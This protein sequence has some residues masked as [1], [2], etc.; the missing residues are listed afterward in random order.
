MSLFPIYFRL[1]L[2]CTK[3]SICLYVF[4]LPFYFPFQ[5][6]VVS[7]PPIPKRSPA[8][9]LSDRR[10]VFTFPET[11]ND[12]SLD[13]F[14][15]A[16]DI[17][18]TVSRQRIREQIPLSHPGC[19]DDDA[20][21]GQSDKCANC[22]R[23]MKK[24]SGGE[25]SPFHQ[26]KQMFETRI[27]ESNVS[28]SPSFNRSYGTS[29][30][31]KR[32]AV[33]ADLS[34]GESGFEDR[35]GKN[36][37]ELS[38]ESSNGVG[39]G[40][41]GH[42]AAKCTCKDRI[43]QLDAKFSDVRRLI[44]L[45]KI[46]DLDSKPPS[47]VPPPPPVV[48]NG[49]GPH[50]TNSHLDKLTSSSK[51]DL[52][53]DIKSSRDTEP[54]TSTFNDS[55]LTDVSLHGPESLRSASSINSLATSTSDSR[56]TD[57]SSLCNRCLSSLSVHTIEDLPMLLPTDALNRPHLGF[58]YSLEEDLPPGVKEIQQTSTPKSDISSPRLFRTKESNL[59]TFSHS[60]SSLGYISS[61]SDLELNDLSILP[62][63]VP[64]SSFKSRTLPNGMYPL[65][66]HIY[67]VKY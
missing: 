39:N 13:S 55:S 51:S 8:T 17:S 1:A 52:R 65:S 42:H 15:S 30:K 47:F 57:H 2:L 45:N 60:V 63:K 5:P 34:S 3:A 22:G 48:S 56:L 40:S 53:D 41:V 66:S 29:F 49:D 10:N 9:K 24:T 4:S 38:V 43:R 33:S 58:S 59:S 31:T 12:N 44:K 28:R 62:D 20:R 32:L 27:A 14:D 37:S 64:I 21:K 7:P 25:E 46:R 35:S 19:C 67:H 18:P 54:K 11:A 36:S 61:Q 26:R 16:A 23:A 50:Q 6:R